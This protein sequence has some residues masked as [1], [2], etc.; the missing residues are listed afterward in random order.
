M[1]HVGVLRQYKFKDDVD[2]IR[3]S[4]L[5]GRDDKKLGEIDDVIFDHDTGQIQ[6]AVVD[7]GGW[8]SSDKF[9]V[10]AERIFAR[11]EDDDFRADLTKE[12][13]ERF[14]EY[15]ESMH[16]EP[17][18]WH[19]Y[20]TRYRNSWTETGG[21]LHK[22]GSTNILTPEADEMPPARGD[23]TADVT[24]T[25]LA[26][27]FT[28]T[29]PSANKLRMRPEGTASRAEDTSI[30]GHALNSERADW[31]DTD[32]AIRRQRE[33]AGIR[34]VRN[35]DR[36]RDDRSAYGDVDHTAVPRADAGDP[37]AYRSRLGDVRDD[38]S[39]PYPVQQGRNERWRAFEDNLRRNRVDV[40]SS[41]RSCSPARDRA[42]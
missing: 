11:D 10:P 22:D 41:C 31:Q 39:R 24:P 13:I 20:E 18:H 28:D 7:T 40:T 15:N 1:P 23:V 8:L 36:L 14:P 35:E 9:I 19:D 29:A 42:A 4:N 33:E 17:T 16:E 2:D 3:G 5:Y 6:Y 38:L 34:E 25:R 26:P 12:Q 32:A 27:K 30:P 37:E 21:V